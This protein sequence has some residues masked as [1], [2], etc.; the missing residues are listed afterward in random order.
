[1]RI[2]VEI[3]RT[4]FVTLTAWNVF[5]DQGTRKWTA[6]ASEKVS[7]NCLFTSHHD[8]SLVES[9]NEKQIGL[10]QGTSKD[11]SIAIRSGR[12]DSAVILQ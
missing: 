7:M 6:G 10:T 2:L 5:A 12:K 3:F 8:I 9:I 4:R 1:M 11:T